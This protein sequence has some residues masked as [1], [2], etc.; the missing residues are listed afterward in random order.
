MKIFVNTIFILLLAT[1]DVFSQVPEQYLKMAV[2]NNPGLKASYLQFEAALERIPQAK[3]LP[4]PTLSAAYTVLPAETMPGMEKASVSLSQMFPWFGTLRAMGDE[5]ALQAEAYYQQYL[6]KRN[7][8]LYQVAAAWYPLYELHRFRSIEKENI[9]ILDTYKNIATRNFQNGS[10]PM[11]DVLRTDIMLKDAQT[12]LSVLDDREDAMLAAFNNLL[13]RREDEAVKVP[14]S[15][16]TSV[17]VQ[18]FNRDS[19]RLN[20]PKIRELELRYQASS[21]KQD[22]ARKQGLPGLGAGL[23]YMLMDMQPDMNGHKQRKGALMPMVT[24]SIPLYRGKYKAAQEEA[25]LMQ[26]SYALQQENALNMLSSDYNTTLTEIRQQQKMLDLFKQQVQTSR[27]SL[28]LLFHSYSNSGNGFE[29]VLRM[30][31]QLLEYE[32][33]E[34]SAQADLLDAQSRI[35]Y[36]T[37]KTINTDENR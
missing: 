22:V 23:E 11:V 5:A 25:R 8:L 1:A 2:E 4:N 31:Q 30:Q 24:I 27:Q 26:E 10:G 28:N 9:G 19:L 18:E 15:L 32:K 6:D 37:A 21:I 29:E 35:N 13:N 33:Q 34:A 3:A 16:Y 20:N 36:L 7:D 12:R 14:D 17:E